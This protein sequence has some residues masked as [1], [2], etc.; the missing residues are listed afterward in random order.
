MHIAVA[1]AIPS[2]GAGRAPKAARPVPTVV[3]AT[4]SATHPDATAAGLAARRHP[5]AAGVGRLDDAPDT[6][7]A[8]VAQP[9]VAGGVELFAPVAGDVD[10]FVDGFPAAVLAVVTAAAAVAP[11]LVAPAIAVAAVLARAVVVATA[12]LH[13][14]LDVAPEDPFEADLRRRRG[15]ESEQSQENRGCVVHGRRSDATAVPLRSAPTKVCRHQGT[16]GQVLRVQDTALPRRDRR[17][18]YQS[19]QVAKTTASIDI[20]AASRQPAAH[21]R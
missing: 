18:P 15:R 4:R 3:A 17:G 1:A 14:D 12:N 11:A 20:A 10:L 6:A 13:S 19:V 5:F 7:T 16:G 8:G 9:A 2:N 21:A